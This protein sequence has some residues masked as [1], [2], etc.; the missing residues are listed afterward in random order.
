M[1]DFTTQ[2]NFKGT[3]EEYLSVV[4]VLSS[5]QDKYEQYKKSHNCWYLMGENIEKDFPYCDCDSIVSFLFSGPYGVFESV[6]NSVD[7][8]ER[9]ADAAPNCWFSGVISGFDVGGD[10]AI[11]GEL[12]DGL[13]NLKTRYIPF[14]E[15]DYDDDDYEDEN[16]EDDDDCEDEDEEDDD[17]YDN[18]DW[19]Y[20]YDPITKT[21][22]E[23]SYIAPGDSVTVTII[24]TDKQNMRHEL[25][26]VS[27]SLKNPIN[28]NCFPKELLPASKLDDLIAVL[29]NS[30]QGERSYR[31]KERI[32]SFAE[33]IKRYMPD[34]S[35]SKLE[36]IKIHDHKEPSFFSWLR[37]STYCP[38]MKKLAKRVNTCVE[39]NR[40]KKLAEFQ[41]YLES[42]DISFP[43]CKW[44]PW[45]CF[46]G[47]G[48][49]VPTEQGGLE[50]NPETKATFDWHGVSDSLEDFAAY[51]CS[52]ETPRE[53][54]VE[55]VII[56][57]ISGTT[58]QTAT[59]MPRI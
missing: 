35:L 57:Y 24:I 40:A 47:F 42:L 17:F 29:I 44:T 4:R 13:L 27:D 19:E 8:L 15:P 58:E 5:Y 51:V 36:L 48:H 18:K 37:K 54:A 23:F 52:K 28:L 41:A 34:G 21:Y 43:A 26:L 45:P 25:T 1:A 53:Y 11:V 32:A 16:E 7:L 39:K 46:C 22:G 31:A 10:Q 59:Y 20:T 56:D 50:W 30:V 2:I 3:K 14:G 38:D 55:R 33:E 49:S 6:C 9:I 12:K